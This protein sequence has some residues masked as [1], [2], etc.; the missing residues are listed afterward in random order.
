MDYILPDGEYFDPLF[1]GFKFYFVGANNLTEGKEELQF[2]QSG[3]KLNI[4]FIPK[5]ASTATTLTLLDEDSFFEYFFERATLENLQQD[6]IFVY[7]EFPGNPD[8][9]VTHVLQINR[10]RD[11]NDMT[12]DDYEIEVEDLTFNITYTLT[13]C[14]AINNRIA[15]YPEE[16]TDED[17]VTFTTDSGCNGTDAPHMPRIYTNAGA[18][19]QFWKNTT[20]EI[21]DASEIPSDIGYIWVD[22][23]AQDDDYSTT[24]RTFMIKYEYVGYND[25]YDI[26]VNNPQISESGIG[27]SE[28]TK[29]YLSEFGTYIESDLWVTPY[30]FVNMYIPANEVIYDMFLLPEESEV[31]LSIPSIVIYINPPTITSATPDSEDNGHTFAYNI[32]E[33]TLSVT[34]DQAAYCRYNEDNDANYSSMTN[35]T[36]TGGV[37]HT[38]D[39]DADYSTSSAT[40]YVYYIRCQDGYGYNSTS[41]TINFTVSKKPSGGGGGGGGG[42]GYVPPATDPVSSKSYDVLQEGETEVTFTNQN[43]AVDEILVVTKEEVR[44]VKFVVKKLSTTK[45]TYSEGKVYQYLDVNHTNLNDE[46]LESVKISFKVTKSWLMNNSIQKEDVALFRFDNLWTLLNTKIVSEDNTTIYYEA[47]SPGLSLFAISTKPLVIATT[48]NQSNSNSTVTIDNQN[49]TKT[50]TE[51]KTSENNIKDVTVTPEKK[52]EK[53]NLLSSSVLIALAIIVLAILGIVIYKNWSQKKQ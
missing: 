30:L 43:I 41:T 37:S 23:D 21:A 45:N 34:T 39:V 16:T 31:S 3:K 12:S 42:G 52:A 25:A 7:N 53:D 22:E 35:F 40:D 15:L 44:N 28:H 46:A 32:N 24:G 29:F 13:D 14:S 48:G 49:V 9:A 38:T 11:G 1:G 36:N 51:N 27:N 19:V 5:G 33:V 10:I 6:R 2:L 20:T 47:D 4:K 17:N 50:P 8:K 26:D 18:E